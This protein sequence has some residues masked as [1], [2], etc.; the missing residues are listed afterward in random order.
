MNRLIDIAAESDIP[1]AYRAGPL[2]ALLRYHNL[3]ADMPK[4][5]EKPEL[6]IGM[7]MDSR[8]HL[9]IPD[10]FAF[11]LRTGGANLRQSEFRVSY[12]IAVG[13]VRAIALIAHTNCGMSGLAARREPFVTGLV[14]AGWERPEAEEQFDRFLP[15][16]EIGNELDFIVSE[17]RRLRTLYPKVVVAPFVYRVEDDHLCAVRE[18]GPPGSSPR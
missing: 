5:A 4:R 7:C 6:L 3:G 10:N 8:K 11:I 9:R 2:G 15:S 12:A 1:A 17:A 18:S 14:D 13:G 16:H